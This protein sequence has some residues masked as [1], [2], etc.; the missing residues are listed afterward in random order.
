M[1]VPDSI[2]PAIP[3]TADPRVLFAAER[4]LLAWQR[5]AIA[6]M[7]LGFVVE[8]FGLFL[9]LTTHQ[10]LN[11]SQRGFSLGLGVVLLVLSAAVALIS[12]RQFR[13]IAKNLGPDVVPPGYWTNVGVGLNI[14][15]AL[16]AAALALHFMWP[17]P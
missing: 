2:K 1:P 6:L 3:S 11:G 14:L 9:Q 5:S 16:I 7:G 10:P 13:Q 17:S 12:A 8:R 15:I 4:T